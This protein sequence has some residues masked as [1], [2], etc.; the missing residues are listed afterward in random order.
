MLYKHEILKLTYSTFRPVDI[1]YIIDNLNFL[2]G[3]I[4]YNARIVLADS[5]LFLFCSSSISNFTANLRS[6]SEMIGYGKS[7]GM[8]LQ[9]DLIS[10]KYLGKIN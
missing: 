5:S 7:P 6:S 9:Y 1:G 4:M 10:Y 8:S 2:L 3:S